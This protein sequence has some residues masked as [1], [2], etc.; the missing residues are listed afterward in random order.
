MLQTHNLGSLAVTDRVF[1]VVSGCYVYTTLGTVGQPRE[2]AQHEDTLGSQVNSNLRV[3]YNVDYRHRVSSVPRH[4]CNR[5]WAVCL[6]ETPRMLHYI[7]ATHEE[8]MLCQNG[9]RGRNIHVL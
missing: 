7:G 8:H 1:F 6:L 2:V 4:A 5:S 3:S 9:Q